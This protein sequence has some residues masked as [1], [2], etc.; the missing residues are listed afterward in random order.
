MPKRST[1]ALIVIAALVLTA[2]ASGGGTWLA[3]KI[4]VIHGGHQ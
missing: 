1:L 4:R 2:A 3:H